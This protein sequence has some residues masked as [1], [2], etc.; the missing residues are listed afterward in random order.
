MFTIAAS[1]SGNVYVAIGLI[2]C[3]LFAA[4]VASS[5]GWALP[6]VIAPPNVVATLEAVQNVG[7]SVGGALAPF[8]TG[9]LIQAR[10]SFA[11][12]FILAGLISLA[13][14]MIY[15]FGTRGKITATA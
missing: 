5:C 7:G 4:N 12:A 10:G 8:I 13:C 11:P 1:Q 9:A 15:L 14:A 6:A 2:G 3:G